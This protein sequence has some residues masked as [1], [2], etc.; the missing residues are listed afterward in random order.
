MANNF[1]RVGAISN[2]HV[3][4]EFEEAALLYFHE[5]GVHL[6]RDFVVPVG[7]KKLKHKHFD[8]GSEDPPIIVEC[9][10]FTWTETGK[11]PSAKL[12]ALNEVMLHFHAAPEKY[13]RIL[14]VLKHLRKDVSLANHYVKRYG[15]LIGKNVEVW[16]FD[17]DTK[18][19]ECV[20]GQ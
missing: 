16:E 18:I 5:T 4:R 7:F 1:Q 17:L 10:S 3:G 11:S 14:F 2:A 12:Y 8:L 19:A 6:Q 20:F 9:K 13:R 15:H